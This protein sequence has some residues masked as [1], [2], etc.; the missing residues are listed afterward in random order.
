M[1]RRGR[2]RIVRMAHATDLEP[3]RAEQLLVP[4]LAVLAAH[5]H[6]AALAFDFPLVAAGA[7]RRGDRA[8]AIR[9][10]H[11][12]ADR[13]DADRP[14][15]VVEHD[16]DRVVVHGVGPLGTWRQVSHFTLS[17]H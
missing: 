9:V 11:A 12:A 16:V 5:A 14:A 10:A 8:A 15:I 2:Y 13:T 3:G 1:A 6:G 7:A 4:P 17:H